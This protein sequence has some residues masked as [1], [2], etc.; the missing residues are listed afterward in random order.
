MGLCSEEVKNIERSTAGKILS[1]RILSLHYNYSPRTAGCML[2]EDLKRY[3]GV[4]CGKQ[5]Q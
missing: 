3:Y 5:V 1:E 2:H 4:R